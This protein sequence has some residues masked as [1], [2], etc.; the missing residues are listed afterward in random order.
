MATQ[1]QIN[2]AIRVLNAKNYNIAWHAGHIEENYNPN[3]KLTPD[4]QLSLA[5]ESRKKGYTLS[6]RE[7]YIPSSTNG[8]SPGMSNADPRSDYAMRMYRMPPDV[9]PDMYPGALDDLRDVHDRVAFVTGL[10]CGPT[11]MEARRRFGEKVVKEAKEYQKLQEAGAA[12]NSENAKHLLIAHDGVAK[13]LGMP[14]V[15][16]ASPQEKLLKQ[17][18]QALNA[19]QET[20]N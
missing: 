3:A 11:T 5:N 17:H 9:D 13:H 7:E 16:S 12:I 19:M 8:N 1:A 6:P 20:H 14:C 15:S 10:E 4:Q 18:Q 2:E